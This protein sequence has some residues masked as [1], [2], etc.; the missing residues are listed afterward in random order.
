MMGNPKFQDPDTPAT[1]YEFATADIPA[2]PSDNYIKEIAHFLSRNR[3]ERDGILVA[4]YTRKVLRQWR[5]VMRNVAETAVDEDNPPNL[6]TFA[7]NVVF[8]YYPDKDLG[9]H[10]RVEWLDAD[11]FQPELQG[12]GTYN[13]EFI[14]REVPES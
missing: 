11:L 5:V 3:L 8:D 7:Q 14:M 6:K 4:N 9:A 12:G 2:L 1:K 10:V 13:L